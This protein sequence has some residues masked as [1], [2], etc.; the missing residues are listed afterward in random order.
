[1]SIIADMSLIEMVKYVAKSSTVLTSKS[2]GY[3]ESIRRWSDAVEQRA[4]SSDILSVQAAVDRG[5][6]LS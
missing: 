1:M 6:R 4:A 3:A 2:E 5:I